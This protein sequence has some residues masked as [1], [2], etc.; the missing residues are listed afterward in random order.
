[1][2]QASHPRPAS[3][4]WSLWNGQG[5]REAEDAQTGAVALLGTGCRLSQ[6][7]LLAERRGGRTDLAGVFRMALD[8]PAGMPAGRSSAIRKTPARSVRPP[9]RSASR[10]TWE[11]RHPVPSKATAPVWASSASRRPWP[12]HKDQGRE[13]GRGWDACSKSAF[14]SMVVTGPTDVGVKDRGRVRRGLSAPASDQA[15]CRGWI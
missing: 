7:P 11:S 8:R 6:V 12:F 3:R 9:R 14:S 4:P 1:M 2:L 5:L 15:C 10:G 13:A